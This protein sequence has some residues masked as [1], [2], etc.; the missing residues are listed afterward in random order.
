MT[1]G[2]LIQLLQEDVSPLDTEVDIYLD[3][4]NNDA[5]ISGK[6]NDFIRYDEKFK[7]LSLYGDYEEE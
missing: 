1:K 6:L 3:C 7:T 4:T 2:E 5:G